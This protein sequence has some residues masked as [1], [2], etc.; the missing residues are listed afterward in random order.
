MPAIRFEHVSKRFMIQH[1]R[2]ASFQEALVNM[3]HGRTGR[4]EEFWALRD[5][6]FTVEPGE[7]FALVGANGSGKSTILKLMSHILEPTSGSVQVEGRVVGLIELGAGFHPD[8]SGRENVYLWGS[9]MGLTEKTMTQRMDE[10]IEFSELEQFIDVAVKHYSVGMYMRL[11]FATAIHMD[12]DIFLMD[13]V[14]AVGDQAFQQKCLRVWNELQE[15]GKT[16]LLVTHDIGQVE[17]FSQRALLMEH[18]RVAA[19]GPTR[20]VIDHYMASIG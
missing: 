1:T 9:I 13:E 14:L 7:T 12:A 3:L 15:Q 8:L 19:Y 10:I 16:L 17:R 20:E 11:G 2:P 18:G 6:D 4:V 5:V